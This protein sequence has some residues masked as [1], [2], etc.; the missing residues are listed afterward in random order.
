MCF[1]FVLLAFACVNEACIMVVLFS[2]TSEDSGS[3]VP[4]ASSSFHVWYVEPLT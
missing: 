1:V 4:L 2:T 3:E